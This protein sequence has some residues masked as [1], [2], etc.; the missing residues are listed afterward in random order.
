MVVQAQETAVKSTYERRKER[1]RA[2][3]IEVV[4]GPDYVLL[5]TVLALLTIG[6]LMV[7]STTY[8][9]GY[10]LY[11]NAHWFVVRQAQWAVLGFLVMLVFWRIPYQAWP[12]WSVPM[13]GGTIALLVILL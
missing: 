4:T 10:Y 13:M 6:L 2:A 11:Q 9:M 3:G 1:R 7:Y 8:T 12:R 5:L